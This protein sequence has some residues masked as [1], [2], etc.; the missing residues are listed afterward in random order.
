MHSSTSPSSATPDAPA[1]AE[2][3]VMMTLVRL[4]R[5]IRQRLPG[6]DLDFAAIV[7]MKSLL[8]RGG[9]RLSTL[10]TTLDVDASTVSRQ[11][12]QLE[13]RG[14]LERTPDTEDRRASQVSL[15]PEGQAR[16]HAGAERRRA[17]VADL[18]EEWPPED[19]DRLRTLLT[20]L[21]TQL[22][23]DPEHP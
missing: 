3:A 17:L 16:L 9:M 10:A 2:E 1:T 19:R 12:R 20:R 4:G 15:T 18:L 5:R 22:D 21:L 14:L 11:V 23:P 7:L 6:E 13:D 8:Q